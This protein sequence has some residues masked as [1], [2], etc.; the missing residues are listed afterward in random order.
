[1]KNSFSSKIGVLLA[2]AG[3]AVGLGSIWKFPY[4]VGENG[5]GAFIILYIVCSMIFGL[6]LVMNEFLVGKLSGKSAY[7]AFR[8]LSGT[9]RWQWF[10]W[11]TMVS[12]MLLMSF[13]FVV[14][15]WCF[16][17]LVEAAS[18]TF[19]NMDSQALMTYFRTFERHA[20]LMTI[21][22]IIAIVL[23]ASVLW[24]DVN[25]GI[26]RLSKILMP[27]LFL[28]LILMAFHMVF[29][30]GGITG[31]RFLFEP[32]FSKL[33]P[34]VILEAVG[35][36]FFTLSLGIGALITYGGYMP[37][38]QNVTTTS[39]QMIV[40]V[41][42]VSLLSGMIVF[43][44]V[45]AYGFSPTEG[46][47]LTFVTL[48]AVF[49]HMFSPTLTSVS[50]FALMC[51]AALTSTISMMEVIVA[52]VCEATAET[53]RPLNR[54]QSVI[55][56][57]AIQIVTN[58][59]CILSMT[60]TVSWLT[61]MGNNFFDA[62]NDLVTDVLIPIG[63]LGMAVFTGWFVPKARYQGSRVASFIYLVILRWL[64]PIALIIIFLN[65]AKII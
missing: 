59:L 17:Y 14:T 26:E 52:F 40:L 9:G 39:I 55:L 32:D 21:Y 30:D 4:I 34:K 23:T 38:E 64:V 37:K 36:S 18:N 63:A 22:A 44:A 1:M 51:V 3:S 12:V 2:A 35:L 54:H 33:T 16:F 24:F 8:A 56:V 60:G 7:G 13:Y 48:P 65:S 42:V 11:L 41:I 29:L 47:E 58:T 43:P 20:P 25:K 57:A 27:L 5:G 61:V 28:M 10:A 50:F 31:L 15:G 19:A 46:P 6:P 62:A 49:Q 53:K 45:F